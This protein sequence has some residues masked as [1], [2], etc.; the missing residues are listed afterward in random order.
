M[1]TQTKQVKTS[2]RIQRFF[3]KIVTKTRQARIKIKYDKDLSFL[4]NG[5]DDL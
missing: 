2:N 5:V 4:Y 1:S 3:E